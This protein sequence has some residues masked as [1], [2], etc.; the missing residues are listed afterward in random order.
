MGNMMSLLSQLSEKYRKIAVRLPL[1]VG[2]AVSRV[3]DEGG[4]DADGKELASMIRAIKLAAKC[5][6]DSQL[7]VEVSK[8]AV[9]ANTGNLKEGDIYSDAKELYKVL[10]DKFSSDEVKS[11]REMVIEVGTAVARAYKE[12]GDLWDDEDEE[13]GFNLIKGKVSE[14]IGGVFGG[15][16]GSDMNISP[17]EDTVLT[18]VAMALS[19]K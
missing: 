13:K 1:R 9:Q 2:Y 3:D 5:H 19:S 12:N 4:V 15:K 16:K 17:A 6:K 11:Y 18:D 7:V 14:F 10:E 8:E